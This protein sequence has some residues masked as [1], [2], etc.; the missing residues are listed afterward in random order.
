[1][2]D[3]N[4]EFEA[5]LSVARQLG[6][7]FDSVQIFVT[8]HEPGERDGTVTACAGIGNWYSRYGQIKEWV[9]KQDQ[10]ARED[11]KQEYMDD[12]GDS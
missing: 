10:H 5:V 11:V 12:D 8:R 2:S 1:M 6:E 3:Q 4:P 7:H 9:I